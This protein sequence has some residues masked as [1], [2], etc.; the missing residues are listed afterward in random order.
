MS[1]KSALRLLQLSGH[2]YVSRVLA[3]QPELLSS[4][5]RGQHSDFNDIHRRQYNT[6]SS[7]GANAEPLRTA[8]LDAALKHVPERGWTASSLV[9]AARDL[10][11]SPAILGLLPRGEGELVEHWMELANK[12]CV[13]QLEERKT[14]LEALP[15]EERV[16]AALRMRLELIHPVI[17]TWPQ[18]LAVA[19]KPANAPHSLSLL[20]QVGMLQPNVHAAGHVLL[21]HAAV[22]MI[23]GR[24]VVCEDVAVRSQWGAWMSCC[25]P[26]R[27]LP[28]RL[29]PLTQPPGPTCIALPHHPTPQMVD[30]LWYAVGDTSTD[31]S[32]YSKRA[33]LAG[34]YTTTSLYMLTVRPFAYTWA[35]HPASPPLACQACARP[36]LATHCIALPLLWTA[37]DVVLRP[38]DYSTG[39]AD[40]WQAL[41]RRVSEG[42]AVEGGL[43]GLLAAGQR[44]SR[45]PLYD[46]RHQEQEQ[47]Q[48]QQ[49]QGQGQGQGQQE[50]G[51]QEEVQVQGYA[52]G[53]E[54]GTGQGG[55]RGQEEQPGGAQGGELRGPLGGEQQQQHQASHAEGR[56]QG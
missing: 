21:W 12:R 46:T 35:K 10:Q 45:S 49:G 43:E 18:A 4:C 1:Q 56:G 41:R 37:P 27:A 33:I 19:A 28:H 36:L 48:G 26:S 54:Q 6:S 20:L 11:L 39:Y 9:T 53:A 15:L 47:G 52:G 40:T 8:L 2:R 50:E 23:V 13:A 44:L 25:L 16:T 22:A 32:W 5:L 7:S 3:T 42:L 51:K 38:Q 31:A 55:S 17:D 29:G 34:V 30:E 24:H 14:E